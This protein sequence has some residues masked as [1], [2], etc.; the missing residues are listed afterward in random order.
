MFSSDANQGEAAQAINELR[1]LIT[2]QEYEF[3]RLFADLQLCA[4]AMDGIVETRKVTDSA[5]DALRSGTRSLRY[6][7]RDARHIVADAI[8]NLRESETVL[9]QLESNN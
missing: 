9:I 4:I 8:G 6:E 2:Q 1:E 7:L 3:Q 5:V